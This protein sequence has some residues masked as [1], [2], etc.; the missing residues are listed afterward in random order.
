[1]WILGAIIFVGVMAV[2]FLSNLRK[3]GGGSGGTAKIESRGARVGK[4]TSHK[5]EGRTRCFASFDLDDGEREDF[6]VDALDFDKLTEG[7]HGKLRWQETKFL[8]FTDVVD[9]SPASGSPIAS[10]REIPPS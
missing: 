3:K 10:K 7:T 2:V 8:S 5:I 6:E 4:K 9:G 1:M